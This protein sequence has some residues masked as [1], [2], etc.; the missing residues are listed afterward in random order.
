MIPSTVMSCFP[1]FC[2]AIEACSLD[3]KTL[4]PEIVPEENTSSLD[5]AESSKDRAKTVLVENSMGPLERF[6]QL[7]WLIILTNWRKFFMRLS[8]Y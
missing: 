4:Q 5:S 2:P 1:G 8:C 3:W 7:S 6:V